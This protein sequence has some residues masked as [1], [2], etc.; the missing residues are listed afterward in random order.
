[1]ALVER[2]TDVYDDYEFSGKIFGKGLNGN[3]YSIRDKVT[4]EIYAVKVG[5][6]IYMDFI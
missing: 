6:A 2:I 5:L 1:M 3:I 4:N